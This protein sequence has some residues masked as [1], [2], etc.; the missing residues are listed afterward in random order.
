MEL[1][2][3]CIPNLPDTNSKPPSKGNKPMLMLSRHN[4]IRLIT[5]AFII[6]I[7][8]AL[9]KAF[10]YGSFLGIVLAMVS[11]VAAIYFMY[12]VAEAKREMEREKTY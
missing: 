5:V 3:A 6:G 2:K 7:G 8:Y 12:T 11:L 9:A 1:Q 10:Y 4:I